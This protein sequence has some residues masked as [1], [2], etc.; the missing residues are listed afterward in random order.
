MKIFDLVGSVP[1]MP[2]PAPRLVVLSASLDHVEML[3]YGTGIRVQFD[4]AQ[5]EKLRNA[6]NDA[7]VEME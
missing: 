6:L 5:A 7:L 3:V 2:P 4:K 1:D